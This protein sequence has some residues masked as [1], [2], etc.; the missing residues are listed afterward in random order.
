MA[1]VIALME[2]WM[3]KITPQNKLFDRTRWHLALWYSGVMGFVL[4]IC[5]VGVYGTI[6]HAHRVTVDRELQAIAQSLQKNLEAQARDI[7][8]IENLQ[9]DSFPLP[10]FCILNSGSVES[11]ELSHQGYSHRPY[12][13]PDLTLNPVYGTDY[14]IRILD[15]HQNLRAIAGFHPPQLQVC[16]S[17]SQA[18]WQI[19]QD[20]HNHR[21]HQITLVLKNVNGSKWGSLQVGRS[22]QDF[23]NYL[24]S[25]RLIMILG[26]PLAMGLVGMASWGLAGVAIQPIYQ[27]YRQIQ[28]FTADA[29]HELRTPLAAI[30]ATVESAFG[31][32][33]LSNSELQD[34]LQVVARQNH[35]LSTL[36]SDL[37]LLSRLEQNQINVGWQDCDLQ[38]VVS[39]IVEEL[40][41]LALGQGITLTV[42]NPANSQLKIRGNEEQIYR[43]ILNI[44][45]NGIDYTPPGGIVTLTLRSMG[46]PRGNQVLLTIEDTGIGIGQEHLNKVFDRFYRVDE[47]RSR[48]QG[49]SGLGL[50]IAKAIIETHQG[51]I[52]VQSQLGQGTQFTI[53]FPHIDSSRNINSSGYPHKAEKFQRF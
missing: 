5:G 21:Y 13:C 11:S 36:V 44:V 1:W 24:A 53:Q 10:N 8:D 46:N 14:Y 4:A 6:A 20:S 31:Q 39:D 23:E 42:Q 33:Y 43:S 19:L 2:A 12:D 38:D 34:V 9:S 3:G 18:K 45:T 49:G 15:R 35:R 30:R 41:A 40:A 48:N 37:L 50:S 52:E 26:L 28:Q 7:R 25:V 27:S 32:S 17:R 29:A 51:Q 22:F 16:S 47:D